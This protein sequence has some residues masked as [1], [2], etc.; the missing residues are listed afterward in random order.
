METRL[1][2]RIPMH[3]ISWG[4]PKKVR[5]PDQISLLFSTFGIHLEPE[6]ASHGQIIHHRT[7]KNDLQQASFPLVVDKYVTRKLFSASAHTA[8]PRPRF[9]LLPIN[10]Y[11]PTTGVQCK[12]CVFAFHTQSRDGYLWRQFASS[13]Y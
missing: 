8:L 10:G 9:P 2:T 7:A 11:F 12:H 13:R 6:R 4:C 5:P 1:K 3:S